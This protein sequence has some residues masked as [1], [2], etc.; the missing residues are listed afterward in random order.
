MRPAATLLALTVACAGAAEREP[1]E[2]PRSARPESEPAPELFTLLP[3]GVTRALLVDGVALRGAPELPAVAPW[4]EGLGLPP[5]HRPDSPYRR[6]LLVGRLRVEEPEL[7]LVE[8]VL[9]ADAAS[10]PTAEGR[11]QWGGYA[12]VAPH[13]FAITSAARRDAL[14]VPR[15]AATTTSDGLESLVD[16]L[17][18]RAAPP[19]GLVLART[20]GP[21]GPT[22]RLYAAALWL[23]GAPRARFVAQYGDDRA[24]TTAV[25]QARQTELFPSLLGDALTIEREG[26]TVR[27][28]APVPADALT[29]LLTWLE[30]AYEAEDP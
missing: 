4:L 10:P 24:A 14:R 29:G 6:L 26:T 7:M 15:A 3:A 8:H 23:A 9:P 22:P 13:V 11:G 19:A 30:R 27:A 5:S 2:A 20:G 16:A 1:V 25:A 17:H 21:G 18:A 28:Q 12:E